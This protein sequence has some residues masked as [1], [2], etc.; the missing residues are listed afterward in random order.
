MDKPSEGTA[1]RMLRVAVY[2]TGQ[3]LSFADC[4]RYKTRL[5]ELIRRCAAVRP[6][7]AASADGRPVA[8]PHEPEFPDTADLLAENVRAAAYGD[9]LPQ[10]VVIC[11]AVA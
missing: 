9:I 4:V 2:A 11:T 6:A 10:E 7:L 3:N 8:W 5:R 1:W